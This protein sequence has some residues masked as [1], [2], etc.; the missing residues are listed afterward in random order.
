MIEKG[1]KRL[2][3]THGR[4]HRCGLIPAAVSVYDREKTDGHRRNKGPGGQE[5]GRIQDRVRW[6]IK[7]KFGMEEILTVIDKVKAAELALFEY[8]DGDTRIKIKGTG[9]RPSA[10]AAVPNAAEP[11]A[12]LTAP[13]PG[14]FAGHSEAD[15]AAR[16]GPALDTAEKALAAEAGKAAAAGEAVEEACFHYVESPMVGTFYAA[17]SENDEPFVRV[18]DAVR[19]GQTVGIVEAMKLMNEIEAECDGIV[20]EIL[21]SNEALVEYGQQLVKIRLTQNG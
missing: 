1:L 20:E 15:S 8:Q 7:M 6:K 13:E 10:L 12:E 5:D 11:T 4:E 19:A 9:N 2:G 17:P 21:V 16:S 3:G 14:A 18:G